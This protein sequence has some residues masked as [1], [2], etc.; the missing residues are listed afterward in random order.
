MQQCIKIYYSMFIWSS[1]CFGR[2][3]AHHQ[4][5]KTAPAASDFAYV[6]VIGRW[7]CWTLERPATSTTNNLHVCK[8]RGCWCSFEL[9]MMG[10]VS[11]ETCWASYK[12]GI[13]N[14]DT[15]LH[16]VGYFCMNYTMMQGFTNIMEFCVWLINFIAFRL[17]E[18][19]IRLCK[20]IDI[21]VSVQCFNCNKT[22][23]Y[24]QLRDSAEIIIII[25]IKS[26]VLRK[27]R[28]VQFF[29]CTGTLVLKYCTQSKTNLS[30]N[31]Y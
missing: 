27:R 25:I 6:K 22:T 31:Y 15:L 7:G 1:T 17:P 13:I 5:L 20:P 23:F 10:G 3:A 9:L 19:F 29:F 12:H 30:R 18:S 8:I 26:K 21:T 24:S 16:L 14:F 28:I 2:H 4:E 11:P